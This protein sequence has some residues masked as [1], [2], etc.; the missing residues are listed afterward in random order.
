MLHGT[1]RVCSKRKEGPVAAPE[2]ALEY[3]QV[4]ILLSRLLL[5]E[6]DIADLRRREDGGRDMLM[7]WL[8]VGI[9]AEKVMHQGHAL[10]GHMHKSHNGLHAHACI[11]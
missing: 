6:T 7:H 5:G 10:C 3:I 11:I 2:D 4:G 8:R 9:V 1:P